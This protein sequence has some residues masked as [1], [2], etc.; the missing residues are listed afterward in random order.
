MRILNIHYNSRKNPVTQKEEPYLS[1]TEKCFRILG[2]YSFVILMVSSKIWQI[3]LKSISY[4]HKIKA[5]FRYAHYWLSHMIFCQLFVVVAAVIAV[6]LYRMAILPIVAQ[7][8]EKSGIG[9]NQSSTFT[10]LLITTTA[11]MINLICIIILNWVSVFV[12][13]LFSN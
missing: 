11:T 12:V 3:L 6:M 2:A 4:I 7:A 5:A 10:S 9:G 1:P 13:S 8:V